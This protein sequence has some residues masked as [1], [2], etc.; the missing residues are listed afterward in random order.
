MGPSA[1]LNWKQL[2]GILLVLAGCG[3]G[4]APPDGGPEYEWTPGCVELGPPGESYWG[5][6]CRDGDIIARL[7][8]WDGGGFYVC[9][10]RASD[11]DPQVARPMCRGGQPTCHED[12]DMSRPRLEHPM[13]LD[14]DPPSCDLPR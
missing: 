9:A 10:G 13:C 3:S 5:P 8:A 11:R 14:G 1:P 6:V 12:G 2:I 4:E 7:C